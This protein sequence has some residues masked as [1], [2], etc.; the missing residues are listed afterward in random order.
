[1]PPPWSGAPC[2]VLPGD[3]DLD[4]LRG[5]APGRKSAPTGE[6]GGGSAACWTSATNRAAMSVR[7]VCRRVFLNTASH[8]S[9]SP[10]MT[11][12][13]VMGAP[14]RGARSTDSK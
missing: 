3:R 8:N 14:T 9:S 10:R 11:S 13:P 4:R 7:Y 5:D 6:G 12:E 2:A 1:M